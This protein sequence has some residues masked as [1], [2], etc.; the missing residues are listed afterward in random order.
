MYQQQ[1]Q[2]RGYSTPPVQYNPS[3]TI[4]YTHHPLPHYQSHQNQNY[5]H[6]VSHLH[7]EMSHLSL[8]ETV[9]NATDVTTISDSDFPALDGQQRGPQWK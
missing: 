7:E 3:Q 4:H 1:H 6:G 2:Q 5:N 9:S 8:Q